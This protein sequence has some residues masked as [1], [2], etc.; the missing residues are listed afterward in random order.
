MCPVVTAPENSARPAVPDPGSGD[1]L[2]AGHRVPRS[3]PVWLVLFI[4]LV[5]CTNVAAATFAG[6]V[7]D[8]PLRLIALS[9]RNRYLILARP[10]V[11]GPLLWALIATVRILAAAAVC[12][13]IGR[14]YGDRA[15]RWFWRFLGMPQ[16][17][18]A[19]FEQQVDKAEWIVV[20][21][22]VGS[23][24]VWAL[25]GAARTPWRRLLPLALVGIAA[26][27]GLLWWL[28]GLFEEELGSVVDW[29]AQNQMWIIAASVAVVLLANLRN[30]RR[31]Q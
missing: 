14:C 16:E 28:S 19:R 3:G 25:T 1:E 12:H 7:A 10:E 23:N 27:L 21:L 17:Q 26:R 13:A 18:V 22:F 29:L 31:G 20:P 2:L 5:A 8:H 9:A 6:L 4:G 11:D 24:I 15:L 30:F